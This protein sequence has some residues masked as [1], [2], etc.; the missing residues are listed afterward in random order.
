M[1]KQIITTDRH[2]RG[3]AIYFGKVKVVEYRCIN[4]DWIVTCPMPS[5][6]FLVG[7]YP[8][9]ECK[10]ICEQIADFAI[11]KMEAI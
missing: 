8:V 10:D 3:Q 9:E 11:E 2:W 5:I 7:K 1:S 6:K 4:N